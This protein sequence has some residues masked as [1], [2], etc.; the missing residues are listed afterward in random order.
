MGRFGLYTFTE[1][2]A[3][4]EE[5]RLWK[6]KKREQGVAGLWWEDIDI[7]SVITASGPTPAHMGQFLQGGNFGCFVSLFF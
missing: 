6:T 1:Q 3:E 4:E 2:A 7:A 5:S